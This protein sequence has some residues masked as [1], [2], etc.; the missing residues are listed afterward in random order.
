MIV[1]PLAAYLLLG[2]ALGPY[3]ETAYCGRCGVL[4][5]YTCMQLPHTR[6]TIFHW[7]QVAE[8]SFSRALVS[9]GLRA[10]HA[11]EWHT[12]EGAGNGRPR[13]PLGSPEQRLVAERLRNPTLDRVMGLLDYYRGADAT[14]AWAARVLAPPVTAHNAPRC[15]LHVEVW[16]T[17]EQFGVIMADDELA[18]DLLLQ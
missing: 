16:L 9:H 5:V 14:K 2:A 8:T 15:A 6:I 4:R 3:R 13:T 12:V 17:R 18:R 11:H 10:T 7:R 1:I